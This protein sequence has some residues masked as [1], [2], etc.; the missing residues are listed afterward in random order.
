MT[1]QAHIVRIDPHEYLDL[2]PDRL[3]RAELDE[4][5][6][7]SLCV[8]TVGEQFSAYRLTVNLQDIRR[9]L[10][11]ATFK[12][13]LVDIDFQPFSR[14]LNSSMD[15]ENNWTSFSLRV[16]DNGTSVRQHQGYLSLPQSDDFDAFLRSSTSVNLASSISR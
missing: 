9:H 15:R 5:Q 16:L 14:H 13:I 6:R 8:R 11:E 12:T 7:A 10:G 4:S 3:T 2:Y 1:R